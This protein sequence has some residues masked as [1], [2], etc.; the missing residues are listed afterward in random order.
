[1][2]RTAQRIAASRAAKKSSAVW[3]CAG[4]KCRTQPRFQLGPPNQTWLWLG[5]HDQ[6]TRDLFWQ[7]VEQYEVILFEF[8]NDAILGLVWVG[9]S[10]VIAYATTIVQEI[11]RSKW[12]VSKEDPE[13]I[14]AAQESAARQYEGLLG[15]NH[16]DRTPWFLL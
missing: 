4:Q 15:M 5:P 14:Q 13:L 2:S 12:Q 1:M 7:V 6:E 3:S 9:G 10:P 8:L 11:L 16:G